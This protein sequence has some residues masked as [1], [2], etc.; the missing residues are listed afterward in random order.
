M[1]LVVK[2]RLWADTQTDK[3]EWFL[4]ATVCHEMKALVSLEPS[5]D[6]DMT[7]RLE[8]GA[9]EKLPGTQGEVEE[10]ILGLLSNILWMWKDE[11]GEMN[12]RLGRS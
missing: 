10:D 4:R 9:P 7:S 11:D 12:R 3:R 1:R 5:E 6:E 8:G 2:E